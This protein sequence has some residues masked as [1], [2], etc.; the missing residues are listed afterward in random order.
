MTNVNARE[1]ARTTVVAWK[2]KISAYSLLSSASGDSF[3]EEISQDISSSEITDG[4]MCAAD[5]FPKLKSESVHNFHLP[6]DRWAVPRSLTTGRINPFIAESETKIGQANTHLNTSDYISEIRD[7]T[8]SVVGIQNPLYEDF[9]DD[10]CEDDDHKNY[11]LALNNSQRTGH[12][13]RVHSETWW[14]A[15]RLASERNRVDCLMQLKNNS[16]AP[17]NSIAAKQW[18]MLT[19]GGR[20][21]G[22][23]TAFDRSLSV[24]MLRI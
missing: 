4:D 15:F 12:T 7:S 20:E 10:I 11:V 14:R 23:V 24:W 8:V 5:R 6:S 22:H 2:P 17:D 21:E 16:P 1:T 13:G 19:F 3:V 18:S 9:I